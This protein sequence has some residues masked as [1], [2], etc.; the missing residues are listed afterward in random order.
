MSL[1]LPQYLPSTTALLSLQRRRCGPSKS[2]LISHISGQH[3][4]TILATHLLL[5]PWFHGSPFDFSVP[6]SSRPVL[7]SSRAR[8]RQT[9]YPI[10][11]STFWS[12]YIHNWCTFAPAHMR[13]SFR[14]L[15]GQVADAACSV[16]GRCLHSYPVR[17]GAGRLQVSPFPIPHSRVYC[18]FL[19][20]RPSLANY[21][22]LPLG[23]WFSVHSSLSINFHHHPYRPGSACC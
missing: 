11:W 10:P 20:E 19:D 14:R 3:I 8:G 13:F 12:R 21:T 9:L 5:S 7:G 6:L 17:R 15:F 16:A 1:S 22:I 2:Y 18:F 4:P 23:F